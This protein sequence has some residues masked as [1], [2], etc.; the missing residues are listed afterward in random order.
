[1]ASPSV[2]IEGRSV[3]RVFEHRS[4]NV[5]YIVI[6]PKGQRLSVIHISYSAFNDP[7]DDTQSLFFL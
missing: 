7:L 5:R 2:S 4:D 3:L 6:R 1:M